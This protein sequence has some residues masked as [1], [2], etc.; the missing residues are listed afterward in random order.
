MKQNATTRPRSWREGRRQRAWAL[1]QQGWKQQAIATALGV[2]QGAISQWLQRAT[3]AG[4]QALRDQPPPGPRP[5]LSDEQLAQLPTLL[6]QGPGHYGWI[7]EVWTTARVAQLIYEQFGVRY[8][9]AH[10]SRLL[11]RIGWSL[12]KPRTQATQRDPS[13]VA[14]WYAERWPALKKKVAGSDGPSSG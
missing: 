1:H 8:H 3:V 4:P 11:R 5:R 9:R 13:A 10:I 7:G 2:T 12:Q 6:A 14:A